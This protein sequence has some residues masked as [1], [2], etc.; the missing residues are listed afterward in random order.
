M[1]GNGWCKKRVHTSSVAAIRPTKYHNGQ[2]FSDDDWC[3]D[4]TP[5]SNA[6]GLAKAEAEKIM[7]NWAKERDVRLVTIHPSV[8][9]GPITQKTY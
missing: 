8:V 1:F 6:Y 5:V 7:R 2:V 4:A 3:N 9:F